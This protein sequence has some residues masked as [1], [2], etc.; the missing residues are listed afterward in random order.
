M[1]SYLA[2]Q[3]AHAYDSDDNSGGSGPDP[4]QLE[5]SMALLKSALDQTDVP[6]EKDEARILCGRNALLSGNFSK[7]VEYFKVSQYRHGSLG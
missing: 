1:E 7:A 6:S 5:E 3:W 2:A 4:A